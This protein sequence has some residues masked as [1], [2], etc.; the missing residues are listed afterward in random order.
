M[1]LA[2][3]D[4]VRDRTNMALGTVAGIASHADGPLI[5]FQV[6]DD[7]HLAEPEDIDIVA[8]SATSATTGW[9]AARAVGYVLA[10]LFSFVAGHSARDLGADWLLTSLAGAGGYSAATATARW[11]ARLVSP[12]RFRV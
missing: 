4:V 12:R 2:I 3:G 11:S 10:A 8:R 1:R 7:L 6:S 5:A 9:K